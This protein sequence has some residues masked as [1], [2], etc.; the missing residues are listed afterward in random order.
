M[1]IRNRPIQL[2]TNQRALLAVLSRLQFATLEQLVY[3]LEPKQPTITKTLKRLTA[4]GLVNVERSCRPHIYFATVTGLRAAGLPMPGSRR[5]PSWSV[6]AHHCHRNAAEI[7]LREHYR[8]FTFQP[9]QTLYAM[10]L[11][12]A[13]GEHYG[14]DQ[15]GQGALVLLDDYLMQSERIPHAWTRAHT[16]NTRHYDLATGRVRHWCDVTQRYILAVTDRIQYE[17][18]KA[19]IRQHRLDTA[20]LFVAGLWQT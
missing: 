11:S 15:D 12:P 2:S 1:G 8:N 17:R 5:R 10:G 16:P 20:L 18:H 6:M 13:H 4:N 3:W 19:Y 9:R 14:Q 7:R